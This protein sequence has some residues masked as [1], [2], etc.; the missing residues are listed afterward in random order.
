MAI[1]L[2]YVKPASNLL[3]AKAMTSELI[4]APHQGKSLL[5]EAVAGPVPFGTSA[6]RVTCACV[7]ASTEEHRQPDLPGAIAAA[8]R[9]SESH[10]L[11]A[12]PVGLPLKCLARLIDAFLSAPSPGHSSALGLRFGAGDPISF[13]D[14]V[15]TWSA[16]VGGPAIANPVW[17]CDLSISPEKLL[18]IASR[19]DP[20][21]VFP[22]VEFGESPP[23]EVH[24]PWVNHRELLE[25][26]FVRTERFI[27]YSNDAPEA[28]HR[29]L[30]ASFL[31]HPRT[32]G[33]QRTPVITLG[34][35]GPA[36]LAS[37][38][39]AVEGGAL[40]AMGSD[41]K[42]FSNSGARDTA[43]IVRDNP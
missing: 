15:A 12:D 11:W 32:T 39:A 34:A 41:V 35:P 9:R 3:G 4:I 14:P 27:Y 7:S 19:I 24:S 23:S 1:E 33:V 16:K 20:M 37:L 17:Y 40:I 2:S 21:G 38:V 36:F 25:A 42:P 22:L 30:R 6:Q 13:E 28:I 29:L 31:A 10:L 5:G 26:Y 43:L 18:K 8:K